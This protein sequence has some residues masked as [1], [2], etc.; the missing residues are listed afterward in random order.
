MILILYNKEPPP[1]KYHCSFFFRGMSGS[2]GLGL[3]VWGGFTWTLNVCRIIAFY[4]RY[5]VIILL[6]FEGLGRVKVNL[7]L[8]CSYRD[9]CSL[10]A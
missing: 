4:Y 10:Y 5:W 8:S 1:K 7:S 9:V 6:A 3:G 2:G